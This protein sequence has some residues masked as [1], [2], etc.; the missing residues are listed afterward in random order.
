MCFYP[1]DPATLFPAIATT[2]DH[3]PT[4][5]S[6]VSVPASL[7]NTQVHLPTRAS[8]VSVAAL[9]LYICIVTSLWLLLRESISLSPPPPSL[10][11]VFY[12]GV[13]KLFLCHLLALPSLPPA[14]TPSYLFSPVHTLN[15][16]HN[17]THCAMVDWLLPIKV[18]TNCVPASSRTTSA[19]GVSHVPPTIH[20]YRFPVI[21]LREPVC[22]PSTFFSISAKITHI[23]EPYSNFYW[24]TAL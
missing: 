21:F 20:H 7:P 22:A 11:W 6:P 15:I 17:S 5:D 24:I 23:S 2:Q 9:W 3:Y 8:P 19:P 14:S 4:Q 16:S 13:P 10:M 1:A 18:I 12:Q